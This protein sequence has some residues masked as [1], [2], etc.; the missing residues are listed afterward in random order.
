LKT[1]KQNKKTEKHCSCWYNFFLRLESY[2]VVLRNN[3]YFSLI[4]KAHV[5]ENASK[6]T[7]LTKNMPV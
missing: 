3:W 4:L 7:T 1:G 5:N 6:M 2:S